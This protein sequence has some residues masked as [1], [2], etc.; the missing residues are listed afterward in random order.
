[1][2]HGRYIRLFFFFVFC[3]VLSENV[4]GDQILKEFTDWLE[5]HGSKCRC[6]FILD[7]RPEGAKTM[8]MADRRIHDRESIFMVP[9]SIIVTPAIV[10]RSSLGPSL[11][12]VSLIEERISKESDMTRQAVMRV[13]M[14]TLYVLYGIQTKDQEWTPYFNLLMRNSRC[15]LLW[16]WT[17]KELEELQSAALKNRAQKWGLEVKMLVSNIIPKLE[18]GGMFPDGL[19]TDQLQNAMCVIQ[20]RSFNI[21]D[22]KGSQTRAL[23]PGRDLFPYDPTVPSTWWSKTGALRYRYANKEIEHGDAIYNNLSP[24]GDSTQV[25]MDH[26]VFSTKGSKFVTNLPR[27]GMIATRELAERLSIKHKIRYSDRFTFKSVALPYFRLESLTGQEAR[28]LLDIIRK[29]ETSLAAAK[30]AIKSP[31][32]YHKSHKYFS[33]KSE[34]VAL[35]TLSVH[36]SEELR[37]M[38]TSITDDEAFLKK[39]KQSRRASIATAYRLRFKKLVTHALDVTSASAVETKRKCLSG[40]EL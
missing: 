14:L 4:K 9:E 3:L 28:E 32:L 17:D 16:Q 19:T 29:D 21:T 5:A 15:D 33:C 26:G 37:G 23:I 7:N 2:F 6:H 20:S 11:D 1:M 18:Q 13:A 31:M 40:D 36:L 39:G 30:I 38:P 35:N 12:M 25:L 22:A 24:A 27:H 8:V 34:V 10:E